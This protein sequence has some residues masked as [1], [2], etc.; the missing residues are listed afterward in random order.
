MTNKI[1]GASIGFCVLLPAD[2]SHAKES[3]LRIL[4][5]EHKVEKAALL[6]SAL[7]HFIPPEGSGPDSALLQ[8][9]R[10]FLIQN[11]ECRSVREF[12]PRCTT[13]LILDSG[14]VAISPTDLP[15]I[16]GRNNLSFPHKADAELL[17]MLH[18]H[19]GRLDRI[20]LIKEERTHRGWPMANAAIL[21]YVVFAA[22]ALV[23]WGHSSIQNRE[24]AWSRTLYPTAAAFAIF[25]IIGYVTFD[26][27]PTRA[28]IRLHF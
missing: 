24:Y 5:S 21:S 16:I 3:L 8:S 26:P 4:V 27:E 25:A 20:E 22:A 10:A 23:E 6:D 28:V 9:P 7:P 17:R 14:R 11:A 12:A 18:Q 13:F 19:S 2:S 15:E 1:L